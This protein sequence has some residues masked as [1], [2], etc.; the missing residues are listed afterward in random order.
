VISMWI[1]WTMLTTPVPEPLETQ[2]PR[3]LSRKP[4]PSTDQIPATH[5]PDHDGPHY[6]IATHETGSETHLTM[7]PKVAF[8][9]AQEMAIAF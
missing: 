2:S 8:K 6:S 5:D 4:R 1:G 9:V 3:R 7:N